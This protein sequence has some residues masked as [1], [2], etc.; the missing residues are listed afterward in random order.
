MLIGAGSYTYELVED[1]AK[2]PEDE[3]FNDVCSIAID[4]DDKLFLITRGSYP[5]VEYDR[6][7][8]RLNAW[9]KGLFTHI[10]GGRVGPDNSLYCIDADGHTVSKFSRDGKCIFMIGQKDQPSETGYKSWTPESSVDF[11][12]NLDTIRGGPPF[13]MPTS[14]FVAPSGEIYVSDGYGNARIHVFTPGGALKFSWGEPG[15]GPG[16]FRV[17]HSVWIDKHDRVWVADRQNDRLQI[18]DKQGAFLDQ[19]IDFDWP[20][21]IFIDEQENVYVAE[22]KRRITILDKN[23][24]ILLRYRDS[25]PDKQKAVLLAPHGIA[26]DSTGSIY[27]GEVAKAFGLADRRGRAIQKFVRV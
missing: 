15:R 19:W 1:W 17:P 27:V 23:G 8:D 21:D 18:F 10:H 4:S 12:Q 6:N 24:K 16:Q 20:C 13:N 5:V 26:V 14:V 3:S 9:G 11:V 22:L 7:G 2:L 25:E